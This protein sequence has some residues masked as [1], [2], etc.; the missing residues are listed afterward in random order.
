M[1]EPVTSKGAPQ[2]SPRGTDRVRRRAA[3]DQ[4]ALQAKAEGAALASPSGP[5]K[6]AKIAALKT[7]DVARFGVT[8]ATRRIAAQTEHAKQAEREIANIQVEPLA[9]APALDYKPGE[10]VDL[11]TANRHARA[12]DRDERSEINDASIAAAKAVR[13]TLSGKLSPEQINRHRS[14]AAHNARNQAGAAK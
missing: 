10:Q 3:Q 11:Q 9:Q 13:D 12:H 14:I 6:D 5:E 4:H 8:K 7:A 2:T 1:S